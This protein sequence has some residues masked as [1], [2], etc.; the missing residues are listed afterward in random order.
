MTSFVLRFAVVSANKVFFEVPN[1]AGHFAWFDN[2]PPISPFHRTRYVHKRSISP[3]WKYGRVDKVTSLHTYRNKS[4]KLLCLNLMTNLSSFV[5][6]YCKLFYKIN[7]NRV[8]NLAHSRSF[9]Y[10]KYAKCDGFILK[11]TRL[12]FSNAMCYTV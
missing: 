7:S 9:R 5:K 2:L 1:C 10:L 6:I 3:I 4:G 12:Y 11:V 8:H